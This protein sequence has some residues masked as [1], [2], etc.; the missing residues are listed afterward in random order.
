VTSD[1]TDYGMLK[2]AVT[3]ARERLLAAGMKVEMGAP[4]MQVAADAGYLAQEDLAFAEAVREKIDILIHQS[5]APVR[6]NAEGK[7]L[8][9]RDRFQILDDGTATCPAGLAMDG[10]KRRGEQEKVWTG[11]GCAACEIRSGC[12][13]GKQRTIVVNTESERLR[14]LM[15]ERMAQPGAKERYNKRIATIEPVFSYLEDVLGFRRASS[16]RTE[17]VVAE[18]LLHVLAHNL[19]RLRRAAQ[20][21]GKAEPGRRVSLLVSRV[22]VLHDSRG[23][24][25]LAA[26]VPR[27]TLP[28]ANADFQRSQ[29]FGRC[30]GGPQGPGSPQTGTEGIAAY[31]PTILFPAIL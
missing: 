29:D 24:R 18:V 7:A 31:A 9:G 21:S 23:T 6:R 12:T 20:R 14:G 19:D 8:F 16:R 22:S 13:T 2:E 28:V 1:P 30:E 3:D 15:R 5:P 17:T 11:T 26:W 25:I 27:W 10:P 4:P